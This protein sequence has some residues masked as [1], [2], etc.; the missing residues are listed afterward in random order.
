MCCRSRP[1][2]TPLGN[3]RPILVPRPRLSRCLLNCR[4]ILRTPARCRRS[5]SGARRVRQAAIRSPAER[6]RDPEPWPARGMPAGWSA[7][8]PTPPPL[9]GFRSGVPELP[10][11][12]SLLLSCCEPC[13]P[14]FSTRTSFCCCVP[15]ALFFYPRGVGPRVKGPSPSR[16]A[17]T[18]LIKAPTDHFV[19]HSEVIPRHSCIHSFSFSEYFLRPTP[20]QGLP[21]SLLTPDTDGETEAKSWKPVARPT[22]KA[23]A[24]PSIQ[25]PP[26]SVPLAV[27]L[28]DPGVSVL[29]GL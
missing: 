3:R 20:C 13:P 24:F 26:Q 7:R 17:L 22:E 9:H 12:S 29:S 14:R 19:C 18:D 23:Q 6:A 25:A 5:P 1:G 8:D 4:G 11:G 21:I 16:G 27:T 15:R 28:S 2:A 10:P